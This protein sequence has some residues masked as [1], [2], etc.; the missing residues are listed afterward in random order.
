MA[1][2]VPA[3]TETTWNEGAAPG[4]SAAELQ[5]MDDQIKALSDEFNIHNGGDSVL[6]HPV[7]T[8]GVLGMMS[9]GDKLKADG[10]STGHEASA[11]HPLGTAGVKG[12]LS[13]AQFTKLAGI[14]AGATGDQTAPEHLDA[15]KTGDGAGSGLD[16][17]LLDGKQAVQFELGS[18]MGNVE[19]RRSADLSLF[20]ATLTDVGW[21]VE[22]RDDWGG[23][24]SGFAVTIDDE[25]A[26]VYIAIANITFASNA[27]G[28]RLIQ[29]VKVAGVVAVDRRQAVSGD[30]TV[31]TVSYVGFMGGSDSFKV[32]ALQNSG[33]NLDVTAGSNTRFMVA[34]IGA[35]S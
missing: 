5:R 16:A 17:D 19:L 30:S 20:D 3:Y 8:T 31:L 25:G 26:G 7:A 28:L 24:G 29:I 12:F 23:H 21:D 35:R 10:I 22:D 14:E 6:D 11:N 4:I 13:P 33:G 2:D 32:Q 15:I 34:R 9:S 18:N 27:T 1:T